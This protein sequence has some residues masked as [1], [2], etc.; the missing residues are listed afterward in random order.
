MTA[1]RLLFNPNQRG[2]QRSLLHVVELVKVAPLS[3]ASLKKMRGI[4]DVHRSSLDLEQKLS[5]T[6]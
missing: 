3:V 4:C 6:E 1:P 5:A 2:K